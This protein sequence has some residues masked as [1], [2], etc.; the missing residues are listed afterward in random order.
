MSL[1]TRTAYKLLP[2]VLVLGCE[3]LAAAPASVAKSA[4]PV[5]PPADLPIKWRVERWPELGLEAAMFADAP[6]HEALYVLVSE[7]QTPAGE[8]LRIEVHSDP[9]LASQP[10]RPLA[11]Q[12][13]W[14]SGE[15]EAIEV[16]GKPA[17][18]LRVTRE[19]FFDPTTNVRHP[20]LEEV[21]VRFRSGAQTLQVAWSVESERPSVYNTAEAMFFASIR[22]L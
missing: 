9:E 8:T 12:E 22:C 3:P 13:R 18:R 19:G 6:T 11:P 15:V 10:C 1:T 5:A 17:Q 7:W 20:P 21:R 2:V 4:P 14:R 16:C